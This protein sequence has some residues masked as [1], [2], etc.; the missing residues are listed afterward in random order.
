MA[1][2]VLVPGR[3]RSL[4]RRSS[5]ISEVGKA[6][7]DSGKAG[8]YCSVQNARES[9]G[10]KKI[11]KSPLPSRFWCSHRNIEFTFR[12]RYSHTQLHIGHRRTL[13]NSMGPKRRKQV[14]L[15][16]VDDTDVAMNVLD[17]G[18]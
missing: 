9:L 17:N 12:L 4:S 2:R 5:P 1:A 14:F 8:I 6:C 3:F 13:F 15:H 16:L 10:T 7:E 18:I 11:K